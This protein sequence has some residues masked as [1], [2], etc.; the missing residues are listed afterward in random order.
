VPIKDWDKPDR[1]YEGNFIPM[2]IMF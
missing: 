2:P 1:N